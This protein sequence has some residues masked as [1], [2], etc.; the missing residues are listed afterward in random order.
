MVNYNCPVFLTLPV[1]P[2]VCLLVKFKA[3]GQPVPHDD[4]PAFL[5]VQAV[6]HTCGMRQDQRHL[7]VVP[8]GN[9]LLT[10][11]D[12]RLRESSQKCFPVC[13]EIVEDQ[14]RLTGITVYDLLKGV[15]LSFMDPVRYF[16]KIVCKAVRQLQQL[17]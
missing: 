11:Q 9:V 5:D 3:P 15:Q 12:P 16:I 13:L 6:A 7:P 17:R 2:C 14:N 4:M 8:V 10:V 1:Q